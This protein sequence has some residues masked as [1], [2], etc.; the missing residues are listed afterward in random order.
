MR[1]PHY[2]LSRDQVHALTADLLQAHLRLADYGR[3]CPAT[4]LVRLLC[5]ACAWLTSLADACDRL[6]RAPSRETARR[7]VRDSLPGPD[8][9]E[10]RLNAALRA[11]WP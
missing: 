8:E 10:R 2:T 9:L 1:H 4:A 7:A 3:T 11:H 5:A 6:R